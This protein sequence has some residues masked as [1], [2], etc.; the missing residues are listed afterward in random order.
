[1]FPKVYQNIDVRSTERQR[2]IAAKRSKALSETV[3]EHQNRPVRIAPRRIPSNA[4][5]PYSG[6][7]Q[8]ARQIEVQVPQATDIPVPRAAQQISQSILAIF[9]VAML[10]KD[11]AA[12]RRVFTELLM[13]LMKRW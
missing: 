4:A 8:T 5:E 11:D 12:R 10:E 9:E 2:T 7:N 13:N 3:A 6:A 1:V